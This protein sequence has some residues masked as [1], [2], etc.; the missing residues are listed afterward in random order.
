MPHIN[1]D[2]KSVGRKGCIVITLICGVFAL[3]RLTVELAVLDN[4]TS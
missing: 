3:C 4:E 1:F 2:L